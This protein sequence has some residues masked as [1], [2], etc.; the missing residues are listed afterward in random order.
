MLVTTSSGL[1]SDSRI[2][3]TQVKTGNFPA[4]ERNDTPNSETR[5]NLAC[6]NA[7]W[8]RLGTRKEQS[9]IQAFA[10]KSMSK[11][12]IFYTNCMVKTAGDS[13]KLLTNLFQMLGGVWRRLYVR[14]TCFGFFL[15][16]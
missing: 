12:R 8:V 1:L 4:T 14:G 3:Y 7:T 15:L 13:S 6:S 2:I 16:T 5:R 9:V 10:E 11:D